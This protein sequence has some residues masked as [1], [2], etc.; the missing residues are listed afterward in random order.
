MSTTYPDGFPLDNIR[1]LVNALRDGTVRD[2]LQQ[3]AFDVWV[4]QGFGQK[5]LLGAP[6]TNDGDNGFVLMAVP[7]AVD[8]DAAMQA[9]EALA[10]DEPQAQ[11]SVPWE[12]IL[13]FLLKLLE[14]WLSKKG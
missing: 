4:V 8:T 6:G 9:L 7:A 14:E 5:A 2:N 1:S 12:L 10:N 11:A 13:A 3:F